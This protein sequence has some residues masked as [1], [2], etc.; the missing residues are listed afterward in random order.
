MVDFEPLGAFF[1]LGAPETVLID[2]VLKLKLDKE[3]GGG[4]L[5]DLQ[6]PMLEP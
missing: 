5:S 3:V 4:D 6:I 2:F 1:G